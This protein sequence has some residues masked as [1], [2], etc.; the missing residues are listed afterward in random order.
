ML[1][2]DD[3]AYLAQRFPA[4]AESSEGGM[5]C[6]VLPRLRGTERVGPRTGQASCFASR[7]T[8]RT[9]RPTCGGSTRPCSA[10]MGGRSQYRRD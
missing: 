7:Q 2:S 10:W 8:T 9:C 3:R 4:F 1:P 6:L 5:L